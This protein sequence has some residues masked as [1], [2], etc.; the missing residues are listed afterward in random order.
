MFP[1]QQFSLNRADFW[2][3]LFQYEVLGFAEFRLHF[4]SYV[5]LI[6]PYTWFR[7]P[8][9]RFLSPTCMYTGNRD[10]RYGLFSA[11]KYGPKD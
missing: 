4:F 6:W 10:G 9:F 2:V 7:L 11:L 8:I 5:H 3:H 1:P